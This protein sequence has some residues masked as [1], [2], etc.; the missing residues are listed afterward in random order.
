MLEDQAPDAELLAIKLR[1]SGFEFDWRR[2]DTEADFV[3][4]LDPAPD[5]ILA[6]YLMP[7]F[8]GLAA[9][10]RV[11]ERELDIP[12]IIVS[13]S[14]GDELAAQCIKQ[15]VAD[16]LL[17]DRLNRLGPAVSN[18]LEEKR[19]RLERKRVE[20][21]LRQAQKM[22]AV[23]QLAGGLAHDFS[24]VLMV[25][26]GYVSLLL[27]G[28]LPPQANEALKIV[29][30]AGERGT[31]LIRQLMYFS[32]QQTM[33]TK[34]LDL[35]E[36]IGEG[37]KMMQRL[38]GARFDV[39]LELARGLPNIEADA[40]MM[41]QVLVNLMLNARDA[42][43][44]GGQIALATSLAELTENDAGANPD[45]RAGSFMRLSVGDTGTGIA[46]EV[47][48]RIFEPLFT[49]KDEGRGTGL[50]LAI[51]ADIV[52]QHHGWIE[53]ESKLGAGAAF[54]IFL[55]VPSA[56]R[57]EAIQKAQPVPGE[58]TGGVETILVLEDEAG[59]REFSVAALQEYGYRVL[60]AATGK[61]AEEVWKW[62]RERIDLVIADMVMPD[63]VT[64]PELAAKFRSEKPSLAVVF[65]SGYSRETMPQAFALA[66]DVPF[67]QKPY[68]P[69]QLAA[70][71]REALDG[72]KKAA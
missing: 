21:Q 31:R 4:A 34:L 11:Q 49:T 48:P 3:A 8:N 29:Y 63:D 35:N 72:R 12:F 37:A 30:S 40:R 22:E 53:V 14:L 17:K 62:H 27:E 16:Y 44:S 13:G 71:V 65:T 54:R 38:L 23:G 26:N 50:G 41:E 68:P 20:G 19:L 43:P 9:L 56:K 67:L 52:A 47:L 28:S 46:P 15:G 2:A 32:R 42:M 6:D 36:V 55:P 66:A 7:G 69:K 64:G 1:D 25:I 60:Q 51:V 61:E 59:V 45:A 10:K 18:V 33:E 5:L 39:S 57:I 70:M 58:A 24:N